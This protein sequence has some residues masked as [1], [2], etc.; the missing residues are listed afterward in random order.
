MIFILW[1]LQCATYPEEDRSSTFVSKANSKEV[2]S[3]LI[4][5]LGIGVN[6]YC[7]VVRNKIPVE[8]KDASINHKK[9]PR[10]YYIRKGISYFAIKQAITTS[11]M[12][13][14]CM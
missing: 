9:V 3:A 6:G 10:L 2:V 4:A 7:L 8:S 11:R 12:R 1:N 14:I 13:M 5:A